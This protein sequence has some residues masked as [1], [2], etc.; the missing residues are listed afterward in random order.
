MPA[1]K[2]AS[3][4]NQSPP[5][6][7]AACKVYLDGNWQ[8]VEL[9]TG[10]DLRQQSL[11]EGPALIAEKMSTTLI[12]RG[13]QASVDANG[14]IVI[15]RTIELET[16][17]Q[18]ETDLDK[19]DPARLELFNHIFMSTAEQMGAALQNTSQSI[20]IKER[21]DFSCAI[22]DDHGKLVANAPHIPVHLGSMS[23]CVQQI[24][25][26]RTGSIKQGDVYVSN[27][28]Y[29]GGTH[30]PDITVVSPVFIE[31]DKPAF[32]L[33][34]RGHHADIGGI[35]PGSMP[36]YSQTLLE[37][38]VVIHNFQLVKEGT[39]FEEEIRNLLNSPPHPAR[40]VTQNIADL[41]AQIAANV[42]GER[43]LIGLCKTYGLSTVHRYMRFV[44]ENAE[45]AVRTAIKLL[46]DGSFSC[47][48][49]SGAKIKVSVKWIAQN[50]KQQLILKEPPRN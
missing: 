12:E 3:S 20:N 21:L 25:S 40:N 8:E 23:A 17:N 6:Q 13:W 49:D 15:V 35:T 42:R 38:G 9:W 41:K 11:I 4:P 34:S 45:L 29:A 47:E 28:P 36:A 24:I 2:M 43:A 14:S 30:L 16:V 48:M 46:H 1:P 44:Q 26:N 50:T 7:L 19:P 39:F 22:F 5:T 10:E 33:A 31:S 32:F 27:N 37:E 18:V